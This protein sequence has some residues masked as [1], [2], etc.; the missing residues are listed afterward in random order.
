M[1]RL[2][3]LLREY[4]KPIESDLSRYHQRDLLDLYRGD[5]T[6]RKALVLIDHLPPGAALWRA[7]GLDNTW[8]EEAHLLALVVDVLQAANWQRGGG[9]GMQPK[10]IARPG[11][12]ARAQ[13]RGLRARLNA[14]RFLAKQPKPDRPARSEA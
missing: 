9:K 11:D 3:G 5:L 10:A 4:S 2:A 6:V 12:V 7:M 14:A 8:T 1:T 13:R